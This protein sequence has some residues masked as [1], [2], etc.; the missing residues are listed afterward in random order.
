MNPAD[1][2]LTVTDVMQRMHLSRDTV[3]REIA[4]GK[5]RAK[6]FGNRGGYRIRRVDYDEWLASGSQQQKGSWT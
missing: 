3:L 4:R 2:V 1:E 5:L 6:K